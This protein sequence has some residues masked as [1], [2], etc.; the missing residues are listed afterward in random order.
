MHG[1][2]GGRSSEY[3][4]AGGSIEYTATAVEGVLNM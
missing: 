4:S 1:H 3:I 2:S